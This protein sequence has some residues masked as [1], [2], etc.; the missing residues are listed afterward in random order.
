MFQTQEIIA[1]LALVIDDVE[2][3]R[4]ASTCRALKA[5]SRWNRRLICF[6]N[7]FLVNEPYRA[8]S[9]PDGITALLT[10]GSAALN[11]ITV[12]QTVR[13]LR[14]CRTFDDY[15]PEN[16]VTWV[17]RLL[18]ITHVEVPDP[19]PCMLS[20]L[21]TL[22]TITHLQLH[23]VFYGDASN[24]KFPPN[25]HHLALPNQKFPPSR[26]SI[27]CLPAKLR[28]L[29]L[30]SCPVITETDQLILP[31]GLETLV[32]GSHF[33]DPLFVDHGQSRSWLTFPASLRRLAFSHFYREQVSASVLPAGLRKLS[34]TSECFD[35]KKITNLPLGLA[36]LELEGIWSHMVFPDQISHLIIV[37]QSNTPIIS[38]VLPAHL[39]TLVLGVRFSESVI[40]WKLPET[41]LVLKLTGS[42]NQPVLGW[43]LPDG[44]RRLEMSPHFNQPV[45]GWKL[46][47]RLTHLYLGETFNHLVI[48]NYNEL[49]LPQGLTHLAIGPGFNSPVVC[50]G[51]SWT[52]P[53]SLTY[54]SFG[55]TYRRLWYRFKT[56]RAQFNQP[57]MVS[58]NGTLISWR[59][60]ATMDHLDLGP[61]FY[62][63]LCVDGIC[64]SIPRA[65]RILEPKCLQALIQ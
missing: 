31:E 35:A 33:R 64:W 44:L 51:K 61:D 34:I 32:F 62:Q 28:Y 36:T 8:K 37:A 21:S 45:I 38:S 17:T 56:Y 54:L 57:V 25:V 40:G 48:S 7:K 12:P 43:K 6:W 55:E 39:E 26:R 53:D 13:A 59:L 1:V 29:K 11:T 4:I 60:P 16:T 63:K 18:H 10:N 41:L 15:V 47:T 58:E 5:Y 52:M 23:G 9:L 65:A 2:F 3:N 19:T 22:R 24:V 30:Q 49:E 27:W 50:S 20:Q 42:F 46:P 14:F